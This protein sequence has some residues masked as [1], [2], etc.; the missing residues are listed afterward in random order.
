MCESDN[1]SVLKEITNDQAHLADPS[2]GNRKLRLSR[3]KELFH[4][5]DN[6]DYI[7]AILMVIPSS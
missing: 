4:T 3:F 6:E 7:G 1:F 2:W 5:R